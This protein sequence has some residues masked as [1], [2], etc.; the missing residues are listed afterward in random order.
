M[1]TYRFVEKPGTTDEL[2]SDMATLIEDAKEKL[3]GH[4][5]ETEEKLTILVDRASQSR[6]AQP[7]SYA[8]VVNN[9]P[10]YA[11]PRASGKLKFPYTYLILLNLA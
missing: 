10:P 1:G 2:T 7:T 11:N 9:P 8:A 5:K 3:N 6:P 4:F